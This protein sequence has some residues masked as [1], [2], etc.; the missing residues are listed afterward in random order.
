MEELIGKFLE[1]PNL[2]NASSF[3]G[4]RRTPEEKLE[5]NR[6]AKPL[7][8]FTEILPLRENA[9]YCP[10]PYIRPVTLEACGMPMSTVEDSSIPAG[11]RFICYGGNR[12]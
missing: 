10:C 12:R 11:F 6:R 1:N 8:E 4:F 7:F 5:A 3:L 2:L 9:R